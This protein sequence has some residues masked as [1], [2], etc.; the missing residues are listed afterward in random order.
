MPVGS[1]KSFL[2]HGGVI[3]QIVGDWQFGTIF[4]AQSG[5]PLNPIGWDAAGQ[6]I[7][8]DG[9]RINAT[10]ADPYLPSDRRSANQWFNIGSF[11]NVTAG[12]F[13]SAGRNSLIGPAV[14]AM[15]ISALKNFRVTERRL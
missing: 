15:D 2:N 12:N 5:R 11:T 7:S 1:G 6:V 4:T 8:P 3:N 9:N 14:W 13:G 10:G